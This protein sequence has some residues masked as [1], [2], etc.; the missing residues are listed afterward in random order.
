MHRSLTLSALGLRGQELGGSFCVKMSSELLLSS[1]LI[2]S[3]FEGDEAVPPFTH[4]IRL[5][6]ILAISAQ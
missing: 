3:L 2:E 4:H 6:Q 5:T 1:L